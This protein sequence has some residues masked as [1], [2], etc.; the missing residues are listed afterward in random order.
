MSKT[1]S[2]TLCEPTS[3]NTGISLALIA[4]LKGYKM[5]IGIPEKMSREKVDLM[6]CLGAEVV[7]TPT[8]LPPSDPE[9]NFGVCEQRQ[10][11]GTGVMLD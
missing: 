4:S 2:S 7:Q 8:G 3:G 5:M 6:K 10:K 1:E 9:S 11:E